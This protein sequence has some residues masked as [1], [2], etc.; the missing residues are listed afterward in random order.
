MG[1]AIPDSLVLEG[2]SDGESDVSATVGST[3]AVDRIEE[4]FNRH[5]GSRATGFMGKNSEVTWMQRLKQETRY[6]SP[7][8]NHDSSDFRERSGG[9]S[10]LFESRS[11]SRKSHTPL[12]EFDEGFSAS[13]NS[14]HVDD[15]SV[16]VE[17]TVDPYELPPFDV[18][19][20]LFNAY[21]TTVHASFP[22]IGKATFS[23][24]YRRFLNGPQIKP[25]NKWLAIL[26]MIFAIAAKYSHLI[27]ADWRGDD[28]DHL[29]Y[30]TRA[31][32]LS[33]NGET[34]FSHPDLQQV[35]VEGLMGFYLLCTDQINR[36]AISTLAN[37]NY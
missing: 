10:P 14:Y 9:A 30:F 3:G 33:V 26:N 36:W 25:G 20:K 8:R 37:G 13:G 32:L 21:L 27:Q 12:N 15:F 11:E 35:Q 29:I 28:R 18:A 34:I 1:S 4:D 7:V 19:E 16:G 22:I 23:S 24:Q 31:R 2:E 17:E 5:E 6:G